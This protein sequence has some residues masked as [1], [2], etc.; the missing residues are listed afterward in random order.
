MDTNTTTTATV[1][2]AVWSGLDGAPTASVYAAFQD[3]VDDIL[4]EAIEE[5]GLDPVGLP[6]AVDTERGWAR[7]DTG[8]WS[9]EVTAAPVIPAR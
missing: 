9:V 5:Y 7:L 1:Y 6:F 4:E 8:D 2:V 3:A